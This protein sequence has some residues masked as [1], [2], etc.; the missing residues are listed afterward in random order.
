MAADKWDLAEDVGDYTQTLDKPMG[1]SETGSAVTTEEQT[2][3][4]LPQTLPDGAMVEV[5]FADNVTG[6]ER[7]LYAHIAGTEWPQGTTVTYKISITPEYELEFISSLKHKTPTTLSTRSI[8]RPETMYPA[9]WTLTSTDPDNVTLR[10]DLTVLT[11][12]GFWVEEDKGTGA[13]TSTAVGDDITVYAFAYRKY[14]RR[15]P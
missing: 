13:I 11:R 15:N 8:S 2:F 4:M 14:R 7:T 6:K 12:R 5:V 1:G 9:G 10:T 3:M